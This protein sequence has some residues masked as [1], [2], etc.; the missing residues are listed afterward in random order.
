MII[1]MNLGY[2]EVKKHF[3]QKRIEYDN[4]DGIF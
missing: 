1:N 3:N 4:G 2:D